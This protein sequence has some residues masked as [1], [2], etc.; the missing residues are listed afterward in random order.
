MSS[1]TDIAPG[2]HP[3]KGLMKCA[4]SVTGLG[5]ARE[6]QANGYKLVVFCIE[7]LFIYFF[8]Q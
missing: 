3:G 5:T 1:T 4:L 7:P 8:V 2:K 6:L